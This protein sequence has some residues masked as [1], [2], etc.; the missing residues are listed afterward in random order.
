MS[1]K[2]NN[3]INENEI[4]DL[5]NGL[6]SENYL[7][8][9]QTENNHLNIE[10][11]KLND[12]VIK[13]KSQLSNFEKEKKN[14]ISNSTKKENDL[15]ELKIKLVQTKKEVEDLKQKIDINKTEQ[16]KNIEELKNQN[17]IL[18]KDKTENQ[19]LLVQLQNKITDLEFQ[20]KAKESQKNFFVNPLKNDKN[21]SLFISPSVR[22]LD[23]NNISYM[24]EIINDDETYNNL[25]KNETKNINNN[26]LFI[27]G[28]NE[29]VEMKEINQK[30]NDE[31]TELKKEMDINKNEKNNLNIQLQKLQEE[32]NNLL[33][34][35]RKKNLE[36]N[37]KLN[38]QSQLSNDLISQL[39]KNQQMRKNF[40]NIKIKYSI[41]SK[42]KKE[43]E[44]VI[45]MQENKVKELSTNVQKVSNIIKL[46]DKE[47]KDNKS[48]INNLEDTIKNL[49]KEFRF[50]RNRK[51]KEAEKKINLLK[52]QINNLKKEQQNNEIYNNSNFNL[53]N[54]I[55]KNKNYPILNYRNNVIKYGLNKEYVTSITNDQSPR[56]INTINRSTKKIKSKGRSTPFI[57]RKINKNLKDIPKGNIEK[58]YK[59]KPGETPYRKTPASINNK[60]LSVQKD[61]ENFY[62]KN[63]S[64]RPRQNKLSKD[65]IFYNKSF[66]D[67]NIDNN[68]NEVNN[69]YNE[70]NYNL[71][72]IEEKKESEYGGPVI[73]NG[74][75][76]NEINSNSNNEQIFTNVIGEKE[77]NKNPRNLFINSQIEKK[78]KESVDNLKSIVNK[79]IDDLDK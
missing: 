13:L 36:I 14:L 57:L 30:L 61:N 32:H 65:N 50:L 19:H 63:Y 27:T 55:N 28:S 43:L 75:S 77:K 52:L 79:L 24:K 3:K 9:L 78:D 26:D 11:R 12:I 16:K 42:T 10:L 7:N 33:D 60:S 54:L 69:E 41:L 66:K 62:Y 68:I 37:N 58:R 6:K 56:S 1:K 38:Q 44:D 49:N 20:L 17:D 71:I 53:N 2:S 8:S 40:E 21:V 70:H 35:L 72:N 76:Q 73:E 23:T 59:K 22:K 67:L 18:Q 25:I 39:N 31:L 46:K 5:S 15:K 4:N 74:M 51:N 64:N 48:Y 29:L 45:F 47:I 34:I